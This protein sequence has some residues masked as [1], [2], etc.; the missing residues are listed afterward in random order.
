MFTPRA[1]CR[2]FGWEW[3]CCMDYNWEFGWHSVMIVESLF[4]FSTNVLKILLNS[5]LEIENSTDNF[6]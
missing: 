1:V 6:L 4:R 2:R 3:M 5:S